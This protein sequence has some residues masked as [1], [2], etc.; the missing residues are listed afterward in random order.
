M[1][2]QSLPQYPVAWHALSPDDVMARLQT[3]RTGLS[4]DE[5]ERRLHQYGPNRLPQPRRRGPL[6]LLFAQFHNVLIYVLLAAGV[7]TALLGH[8]VDAGVIFGVVLIN[9]L[10]GVLQEGKAERALDAIRQML[11]PGA[12]V[13]R[14]GHKHEVPADRLV[15]GDIV[16]LQSGDKVPADLRLF[17]VKGLRVGEAVLTGESAPVGKAVDCEKAEAPLAERRSLAFSGTLVAAGQAAGVV[18]ATGASSEIGRIS[19][20]LAQVTTLTTPLLRQIARFGRQL[21]VAILLLAGTTFAYGS[22]V[23]GFSASEMFLAAVGLAVAA[24]PEGLPA[25]MTITLAIGVQRMAA[26]NAIIRRLPAVE[27]L[28]SVTV[29]CSDKTG[30]LTRNEMM[31]RSVATAEAVYR[32]EGIGYAPV[33]GW[34]GVDGE[35]PLATLADVTALAGAAVLCN[36]A[37]LA[38]R[39]GEWQVTGDPMEGALLALGGKAGLDAAVEAGRCPRLDAIPF[40]SEHR[41]MATL[42]HDHHGHAFIIA[43]GAPEQILRMCHLQRRQGEDEVLDL[44]YWRATLDQIAAH[45]ERLLALAFKAV[46]IE[47]RDLGF[48]DMAGGF[49]LLGVIGLIDPARDEAISAVR[50]CRSAGI[51]VKMIT[52]DHPATAAAIGRL[53]GLEGLVVGQTIDGMNDD[54]LARTVG[55]AEIF[56]RTAPEHKLRLVQA[57]QASGAVVAMTGDGVNDA[58]ALKRADVGI[59]MGRKGTEAAKEAAE[60]VL[61]DDNFASIAHA[62][63]EGRTVY[64]NLKKAILFILPTNGAEAFTLVVAIV[65][66]LSLPITAKQIL[67][68]NMITAVTLGLALA[69]EAAEPGIMR[70]PPRPAAEPL[71][72]GFLLWRIAL[73]SG[74]VVAAVMGLYL[75]EITHDADIERARTVAVNMLV[76][77]EIV[78]LFNVRQSLTS[79]LSREGLLGSRSVLI[80][81]AVVVFW[82]VLFTYAPPMQTLFDTRSIGIAAWGRILLASAAVFV[83]VEM[84]KAALRR[85]R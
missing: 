55:D 29:I 81:V 30:T 3:S 38:E 63:E 24:I 69:F 25:I 12:T 45:G 67:W 47:H 26:R 41:F 57:L 19:A 52:G 9:A 20:M 56:A 50:H 71:L 80:A 77:G 49:S 28:G 15:P 84:E 65:L 76:A 16:L 17:H 74:L 22:L 13:L 64:D 4:N 62:V 1:P 46:E 75:W 42:H 6:M 66:G 60:M 43:K 73:V 79:A 33:G 82:Q 70:R 59:A 58:P 61:A 68:V 83:A 48:D 44:P 10:I 14:D 8:W 51:A 32:I 72:S 5:A 35:V 53:L 37:D 18:V 31:V 40:E 7:G 2:H 34:I 85:W 23:H 27:T 11:S 78:Y 36:D 21:T 39:D 54:Q